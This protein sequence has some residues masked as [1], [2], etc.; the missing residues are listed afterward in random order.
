MVKSLIEASTRSAIEAAKKLNEPACQEFLF[1]AAH[2]ITDA[3]RK[4]NKIL[5]AGNGGSLADAMHFAEELTGFFRQKRKALP[6]IALADPT[7]MSCVGND[8]GFD[9]V[10][11]RGV[12]AYGQKGDI[13]IGLTTS[14]NSMNLI[15]AFE[16]ASHSGLQTIAFLG[17]SGGQLRG[18]A[19]LEL[20]IDGFPFSDRIQEA[21]MAV[22][23]ILIEAVESLL[24]SSEKVAA[25][26]SILSAAQ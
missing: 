15:K 8:V 12:E 14:G 21:H 17:K 23:H 11:S 3:F 10:F 26:E 13:F 1:Q 5:I 4:G 2:L 6:A 9:Q 7:H 18:A 19:D 22:I 20:I 16:A 24:F 25:S